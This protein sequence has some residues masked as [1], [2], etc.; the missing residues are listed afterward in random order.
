M[1]RVF[2]PTICHNTVFTLI[3]DLGSKTNKIMITEDRLK[4]GHIP[5]HHINYVNVWGLH[6]INCSIENVMSSECKENC[7]TE[8]K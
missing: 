7:E 6:K 3:T 1:F 2:I 4:S 8:L 5:T